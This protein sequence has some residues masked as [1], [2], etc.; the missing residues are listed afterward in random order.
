MTILVLV[1]TVYSVDAGNIGAE[2]IDTASTLQETNIT[3]VSPNG[4]E[5]WLRDTTYSIK[6][7]P[8][9]RNTNVRLELFK[10]GILTSTISVSTQNDGSK[11]WKIPSTQVLGSDYK[12]KITNLS[13]MA[14]YDFSDT[15]FSII[16][17]Y[18]TVVSPNGGNNWERGHD[19]TIEWNHI[20]NTG[21]N[22]KIELFR[23]NTLSRRISSSTSND[24]S[25]SWYVPLSQTLDNNYKIKITSK[26]HSKYYDWSDN[27]FRIS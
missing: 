9:N 15:N 16:G 5:N 23:G 1:S 27:Y 24:G 26:S 8:S 18:I 2:V 19:Y 12:I 4:G 20:G 3:I 25:Y 14:D 13:N 11:S 17:P 6:W 10:T 22:V 7:S 21:S